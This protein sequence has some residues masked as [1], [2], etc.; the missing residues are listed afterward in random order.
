DVRAA[1][2]LL[3]EAWHGDDAHLVA[4]LF[5]EERHRAGGDRLLRRLDDGVDRRVLQ[6]VLVNNLLDVEQ[7]LAR[8]RREVDEVEAQAIL[9]DERARLLYVRA[10]DLSKRSMKQVSGRV[11]PADR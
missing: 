11:I 1:A 8:E 7:L 9:G 10:E 4:V 6:H 5:A 2:Q 3:A